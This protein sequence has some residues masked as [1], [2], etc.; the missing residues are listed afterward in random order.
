MSP[1]KSGDYSRKWRQSH[2]QLSKLGNLRK[3]QK[4]VDK[5]KEVHG[6]FSI[7]WFSKGFSK[8]LGSGI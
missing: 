5:R 3:R 1:K 8:Y 6:T 7:V 2:P 4:N